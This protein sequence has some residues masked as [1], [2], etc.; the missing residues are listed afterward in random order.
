MQSF[1]CNS[2]IFHL[3]DVPEMFKPFANVDHYVSKKKA[4]QRLS[5]K[6]LRELV[7]CLS[8]NLQTLGSAKVILEIFIIN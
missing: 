8:G 1:R 6:E 7:E 5:V 2:V 4:K 3:P